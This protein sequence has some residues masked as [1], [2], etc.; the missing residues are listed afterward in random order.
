MTIKRP[1]MVGNLQKQIWPRASLLGLPPEVRLR[2]YGH[3]WARLRPVTVYVVN[4]DCDIVT[5]EDRNDRHDRNIRFPGHLTPVDKNTLALLSTCKILSAEARPV[6]FEKLP[7]VIDLLG[8]TIESSG[9]KSAVDDRMFKPLLRHMRNV[10][11]EASIFVYG[12]RKKP[13]VPEF[14]HHYILQELHALNARLRKDCVTRTLTV[15]VDNL[16]AVTARNCIAFAR[17]HWDGR[18]VLRMPASMDRSIML[19]LERAAMLLTA[20][21]ATNWYVPDA[22]HAVLER[23]PC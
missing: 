5:C 9:G 21:T 23:C 8:H 12:G 4:G 11:V 7:F 2:I 3:L 18:I 6:M 16:A 19:D 1:S 14:W 13:C 10:S 15:L 17:I 22:S 20:A